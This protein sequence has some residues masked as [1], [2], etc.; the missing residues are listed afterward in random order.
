MTQHNL[1]SNKNSQA[2]S[3][4]NW[5]FIKPV[6]SNVKIWNRDTI[7]QQKRN[8][9]RIGFAIILRKCPQ[10]FFFL[11]R[12]DSGKPKPFQMWLNQVTNSNMDICGYS[13]HFFLC[14]LLY[15]F[16]RVSPKR[17]LWIFFLSPF[18]KMSGRNFLYNFLWF[19]H[20][21]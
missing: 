4:E 6:L 3:S 1:F 15:T 18:E 20:I 14:L 8:L 5:I 21:S 7:E 17:I 11:K 13:A 19:F 16:Q 12:A 10:E 2:P 9:K